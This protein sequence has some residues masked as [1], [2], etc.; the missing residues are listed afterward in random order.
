LE[1]THRPARHKSRRGRGIEVGISTKQGNSQGFN[2]RTTQPEGI[3]KN[4]EFGQRINRRARGRGDSRELKKGREKESGGFE[5]PNVSQY[6]QKSKHLPIIRQATPKP[7]RGCTNGNQRPRESKESGD[8]KNPKD[9]TQSH[10]SLGTDR[11]LLEIFE[12]RG[13]GR[14]K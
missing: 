9:A 12:R 7:E 4:P 2:L 3:T 6:A 14:V 5:T 10:F 13:D 1:K 11:D 8:L